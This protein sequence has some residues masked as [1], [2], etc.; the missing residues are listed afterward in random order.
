MEELSKILA[1]AEKVVEIAARDVVENKA[2]LAKNAAKLRA[3]RVKKASELR[4]KKAF[5]KN[6]KIGAGIVAGS[7]ALGT[8]AYLYNK[9]KNKNSDSK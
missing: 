7:A 1:L 2:E 9:S 4:A 5:A 3:S 6:T 8:G